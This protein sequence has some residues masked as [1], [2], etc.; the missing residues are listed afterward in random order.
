MGSRVTEDLNKLMG[1]G[2]NGETIMDY[3]IYDATKAGFGKVVFVIRQSWSRFPDQLL[4]ETNQWIPIDV[5]IVFQE[6]NKVPEGCTYI[7]ER[8]NH[9]NKS[10]CTDGKE[11]IHEPLK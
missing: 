7:A 6:I 9:K 8:E 4:V 3:L 11:V 10:R 5:K 1:L 2:P